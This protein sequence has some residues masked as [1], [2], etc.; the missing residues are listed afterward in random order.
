M[1]F[2]NQI[3]AKL[4][5]IIERNNHANNNPEQIAEELATLRAENQALSDRLQA[6]EASIANL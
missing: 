6:V 5:E 3:L 1:A 2:E 4:T